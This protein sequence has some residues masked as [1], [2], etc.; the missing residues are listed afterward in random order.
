[1][2]GVINA[3]P[4]FFIVMYRAFCVIAFQNP[5]SHTKNGFGC[6][7]IML[8]EDTM[9]DF[10]EPWLKNWKTTCHII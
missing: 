4:F 7:L 10:H 1:M 6:C 3:R 8:V 9:H 2:G 5:T